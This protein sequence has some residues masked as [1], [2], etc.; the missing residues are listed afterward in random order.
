M[1]APA[2][3]YSEE[4]SAADVESLRRFLLAK[5]RPE[6]EIT[7]WADRIVESG[8]PERCISHC[9]SALLEAQ[10]LSRGLPAGVGELL[11]LVVMRLRT[12]ALRVGS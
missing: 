7:S 2:L 9:R 10:R 12:E 3:F 1:N 11:E 8:A 5:A 6:D 4:A